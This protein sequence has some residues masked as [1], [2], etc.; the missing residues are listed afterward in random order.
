M[1][2]FNDGNYAQA[3]EQFNRVIN[4]QPDNYLAISHRGLSSVL[5]DPLD[6]SRQDEAWNSVNRALALAQK[7]NFGDYYRFTETL[8]GSLESTHRTMFKKLE[9]EKEKELTPINTELGSA[10]TG[11]V[12]TA[13]LNKIKD[14]IISKYRYPLRQ[15]KNCT[16]KVKSTIEAEMLPKEE[17]AKVRALDYWNNNPDEQAKLKVQQEGLVGQQKETMQKIEEINSTLVE[18]LTQLEQKRKALGLFKISEKAKIG[19]KIREEKISAS[20][21]KNHL[22]KELSDI[23]DKITDHKKKLLYGEDWIMS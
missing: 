15:L 18:T 7:I 21:N 19:D 20:R 3:Y 13:A 5:I 10:Q 22:Q 12:R 17:A 4:I 9:S 11:L 14:E 2:T 16:E 23:K 1:M 8:L 6:T